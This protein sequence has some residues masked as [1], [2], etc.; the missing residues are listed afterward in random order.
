MRRSAPTC[1]SGLSATFGRALLVEAIIGSVDA[2]PGRERGIRHFG[3]A[4]LTSGT[5][6]SDGP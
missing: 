6:T 3:D 5:L 1:V 2:L 4:L